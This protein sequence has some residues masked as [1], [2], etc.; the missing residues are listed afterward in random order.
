MNHFV[1]KM[2][3][4]SI[5]RYGG[6]IRLESNFHIQVLVHFADLF[7][8]MCYNLCHGMLKLAKILDMS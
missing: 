1:P 8:K 2:E 7:M 5:K 3:I 4:M 6:L